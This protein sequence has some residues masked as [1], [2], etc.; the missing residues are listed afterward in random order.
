MSALPNLI[1]FCPLPPK[2]NGIATYLAEQLPI[3]CS[4]YRCLVVIEDNHP[5]PVSIPDNLQVLRLSEYLQVED[6]LSPVTHLYHIGNN[7]DTRYLMPVLYRRPGI[8]VLHD[9]NIHHLIGE[10]TLARGNPCGYVEA[11]FQQYGRLGHVLG[12][13]LELHGFKGQ[14]QTEELD[15]SGAI[16]ESALH[17]IVH[18]KFSKSRLDALATE[19]PVTVIQH[20]LSR[21]GSEFS[22]SLNHEYREQLGLPSNIP[23]FTSLG[24]IAKAKQISAVLDICLKLKDEGLEFLYVLAGGAKPEEY[25]VFTEIRARGLSDCVMVTGYLEEADFYRHLH[26]ADFIVN[27]RYPSGGETSGTFIRAMGAGKCCIVNNVGPFAEIPDNCAIKINWDS[28]FQANLSQTIQ[29]L[30]SDSETIGATGDCAAEWVQTRQELAHIVGLYSGVVDSVS[31]QPLG[32]CQ[33]PLRPQWFAYL[34]GTIIEEWKGTHTHLWRPLTQEQGLH[35]WNEGLI[36]ISASPF[37]DLTVVG[38]DD[39]TLEILTTLFNYHPDNI[40]SISLDQ[41]FDYSDQAGWNETDNILVLLTARFWVND[42]V[43][44]FSRVNWYCR[45]GAH[46]VA[47]ILW[48]EH[49]KGDV[50]LLPNNLSDISR[51]AGFLPRR[52]ISEVSRA[53]LHGNFDFKNAEEWFIQAEISSRVID[54][55]PMPYYDGSYSVAHRLTRHYFKHNLSTQTTR[56]DLF[57]ALEDESAGWT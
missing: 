50:P 49:F 45:Q 30:L 21:Y 8:V 56:G 12:R 19:T 57:E 9:F 48:S 24:F 18:S 4:Y 36:P 27:L 47:G 33:T 22:S 13:H 1:F 31:S 38:G 53:S 10:L 25:D 54:R 46:V 37:E 35:W 7:L 23:V 51:A 2:K 43:A 44:I 39:K 42:P 28:C 41:F 40:T 20:H 14:Q 6:Q 16:L 29:Q 5:D 3:W 26:A 15:F 32:D 17:V 11:L 55:F 52:V 34:P